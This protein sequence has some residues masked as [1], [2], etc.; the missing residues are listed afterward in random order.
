MSA[1]DCFGR[2]GLAPLRA[3]A[4]MFALAPGASFLRAD[5]GPGTTGGSSTQSG[6]TLKPGAIAF[7]VRWDYTHFENLTSSQI[8]HRAEQVG[9]EHAHFD[10]LRWNLLTTF[11]LSYGVL[12]DLQLSLST[13][14]YR[15]DD[16]REGHVEETGEV[17]THDHGDVVGWTDLWVSGKYRFLKGPYGQAAALA[18]VKLPTGRDDVRGAEDEKL[19]PTLQPGSGAFDFLAGAAY[20]VW[21]VERLSLDASTSYTFRTE[22]DDFKVGDRI[23]G[24][25]AVTY[26]LTQ[27]VKSFPQVAIFVEPSIRHVFKTRED[28]HLVKNTGGTVLFL[29]PGVR[30][31]LTEHVSFMLA[32]QIP[33]LQLLNSEQQ[34]TRIKL[35]GGLTVTF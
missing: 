7:G 23:D 11:E 1:L 17:E 32:P 27:D 8:A 14:L 4:L 3:V 16:V 26:R 21:L 25:F 5:H 30:I 9:G 2:R 15:G 34:E 28:G 35:L 18:G 19:E 33:L 12:E 20:S 29:T 22:D 6:E 13:G 24:G 31:G 10:A